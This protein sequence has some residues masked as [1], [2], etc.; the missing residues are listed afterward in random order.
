MLEHLQPPFLD[1]HSA[2]W[3][4]LE[5]Y[6]IAP[7]A[8]RFENWE[9]YVAGKVGLGVA[10]DYALD[11]GLDNIARR[12]QGLAGDLRIR[13]AAL[14]GITVQDLGQEKFGIISFSVG[15]IPPGQVTATMAEAG[16]NISAAS[17]LSTLHDTEQRGIEQMNRMGVHYY[18]SEAELDR[19]MDCLKLILHS[20]L[21]GENVTD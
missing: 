5:S 9:N 12:V 21:S 6:E 17:T 20:R 16:I 1:L 10:V 2:V 18:N 15:N 13:M 3:K 4:T 7:N 14:P 11:I 19:F 8:R